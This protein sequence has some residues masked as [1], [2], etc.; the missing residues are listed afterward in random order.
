MA[1]T[2]LKVYKSSTVLDYIDIQCCDLRCL[3]N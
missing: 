3:V 2:G 1:R